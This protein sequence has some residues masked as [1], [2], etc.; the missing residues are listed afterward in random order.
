MPVHDWTQV[1][2]GIFH[3][4]HHGWIGA[5]SNALNEG[6]GADCKQITDPHRL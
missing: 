3:A 5:I 4:F 1:D 2:A 6:D